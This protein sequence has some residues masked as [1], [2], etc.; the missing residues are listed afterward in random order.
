MCCCGAAGRATRARG[1]QRER[2][3]AR[4]RREE[5][6]RL[7]DHRPRISIASATSRP[8]SRSAPMAARERSPRGFNGLSVSAGHARYVAG[9]RWK[10]ATRRKRDR[11]SP[12]DRQD[13][14]QRL[15]VRATARPTPFPGT[16]DEQPDLPA[17]RLRS[18]RC[19][20]RFTFTAKDPLVLGVGLAA[21]RDVDR[22]SSASRQ[23]TTRARPI[24]SPG[25]ASAIAQGTSQSGNLLKTIP[26]SRLQRGRAAGAKVD[27]EARI[28]HIAARQNADQ[29]PLRA[30]RR[31]RKLSEHGSEPVLWW[32]DYHGHDARA[33]Q[34]GHADALPR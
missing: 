23:R 22:R 17:R 5:P 34:G 8:G 18:E 32:E 3:G 12:D 9:R 30:A 14:E 6:R 31:R 11:A 20:Y 25:C 15:G 19:L 24:R 10:R 27:R 7:V 13:S 4:C 21:L 1:E 2:V 33:R 16:P 26:P 29:L 28:P